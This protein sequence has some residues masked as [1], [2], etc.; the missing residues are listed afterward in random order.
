VD[1]YI[2]D[3]TLINNIVADNR[4]YSLGAGV[5]IH[6]ASPHLLHNTI[7]RN[8]GSGSGGVYVAG[9]FSLVTLDNTILAGHS[10]GIYV[11]YGNTARLEGTLWGSGAWANGTDRAGSGISHSGD[12]T[13]DPAFVDPN[14]GDYHIGLGS[15]AI[16]AGVDAGVSTD[17]DGDL[18]PALGDF[19]IG[20]DEFYPALEVVKEAT[21]DPVE[22]GAPL[23]YTIRVTNTGSMGLHATVTDTLPLSVTL[24]EASGGTLALPG[25]TLVPPDGTVRLPDGRV[26]VTWAGVIIAPGE[27]WEGTLVV[28]VDENASGSLANQVAVTTVEGATGQASVTVSTHRTI[29]L[30]LVMRGFP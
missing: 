20:A 1:L 14:N 8:G 25:G 29:Y 30:S 19:D 23:T 7:A 22:P 24:H 6:S 28:T 26:A 16:D 17:I 2:S 27:V 10:V 9:E 18:R 11:A 13:G 5:S 3:A 4:A 12:R 15:A 21:P